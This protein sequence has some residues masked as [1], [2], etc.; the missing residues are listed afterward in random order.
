MTWLRGFTRL[1]WM[2]PESRELT[3]FA[4]GRASTSKCG[5]LYQ[6]RRVPMGL[7]TSPAC[8]CRLL[9]MVLRPILGKTVTYWV[10]DCGVRG[11][12]A[13]ELARAW[14]LLFACLRVARLKISVDKLTVAA[15]RINFLGVGVHGDTGIMTLAQK[16][17][18]KI[19]RIERLDN[20]RAVRSF[21]GMC[22]FYRQW[23]HNYSNIARPLT[24]L[25][26]PHVP[27]EW[28]PAESRALD[29]LKEKLLS[30]PVLR[31]PDHSLPFRVYTDAS[32]YT[33]AAAL[34]QHAGDKS[35]AVAYASQAL[36]MGRV[37]QGGAQLGERGPGG[38][39]SGVRMSHMAPHLVWQAVRAVH[40]Q[41]SSAL[42][43][44]L[45]ETDT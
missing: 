39:R 32:K 19:G 4:V 9:S 27:F 34:M 26:S 41:R 16:A 42:L 14:H 23:I 24:R 35:W 45:Q 36:P 44:H 38:L 25:T 37:G 33:V 5:G 28:G 11:E 22:N 43:V 12:N 8:F 13:R 40:G 10:D 21:L 15:R 3:A 2:E 6:Y 29:T 7:R 18:D 17:C 20:V 1:S 31:A 30:E